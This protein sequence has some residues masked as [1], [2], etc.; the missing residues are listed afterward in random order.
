MDSLTTSLAGTPYFLC[1]NDRIVFVNEAF[2]KWTGFLKEELVGLSLFEASN[3]LNLHPELPFSDM[4]Q[5]CLAI[6]FM[7]DKWPKQAN[8]STKVDPNRQRCVYCFTEAPNSDLNEFLSY[9]VTLFRLNR[10]GVAVYHANGICLLA[11]STY[12]SYLTQGESCQGMNAEEILTGS[13]YLEL[14]RQ[15]FS[16]HQAIY[17]EDYELNTG[18]GKATYW[19][20]SM[21]PIFN[22]GSLNYVIHQLWDET[23]SILRNKEIERQKDLYDALFHSI[24]DGMILADCNLRIL[25]MNQAAK[26]ILPG[27][28]SKS[29]I[30]E[31][32]EL[33]KFSLL[34][35]EP[36]AQDTLLTP[37]CIL[38][39]TNNNLKVQAMV[40]NRR[41]I[42]QISMIPIMST[43]DEVSI[44]Y[45]QIIDITAAEKNYATQ[46]TKGQRDALNKIILKHNLGFVRFSWPDL[47]I[48]GYNLEM[49]ELYS[50]WQGK[51]S[52]NAFKKGTPLSELDSHNEIVNC[53]TDNKN[54]KKPWI[55]VVRNKRTRD[56][57]TIEFNTILIHDSIHTLKEI[58]ITSRN[59]TKE[60]DERE[61]MNHAIQ[62]QM[63]LF[64]NISH[65]LKT[66]LNLIHST[67]QLM[68]I[69]I[70]KTTLDKER[71]RK[72][73]RVIQ[74]NSMRMTRL[75]NNILDISKLESGFFT[76]NPVNIDIVSTTRSIV[77]SVRE[78]TSVHSIRIHFSTS[79]MQRV[80]ACDPI[81]IERVLLNLISNAIKFSG[82]QGDIY[83]RIKELNNEIVIY[84]RDTGRGI[85]HEHLAFL[86]DRFYRAQDILSRDT[87]GTGIGLSLV[88]SLIE[89]LHG[90][91]TMKSNP[92]KGTTVRVSLPTATLP[93]RTNAVSSIEDSERVDRIKVEFS[94]IYN[95]H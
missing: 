63:N 36:L 26:R 25:S 27:V 10:Y 43:L 14:I 94:D 76:I 4:G 34:N 75:I 66:P 1:K 12:T 54:N 41:R 29:S 18:N 67:N 64:T 33:A 83:V 58:L 7:K 93:N 81:I 20:I 80:I 38:N 88:K 30:L 59:V 40:Q 91:I 77:D 37:E 2:L 9:A 19:D 70:S 28:Q 16:E 17:L 56:K 51:N 86:F 46:Y 15:V 44:F 89:L 48:L 6:L 49:R 79:I 53:I 68:Q 8:L 11:N 42:L 90:K 13:F 74:Q 85:E 5:D 39:R 61:L 55:L 72:G 31:L 82:N 62:S 69:A 23:A 92:G 45:I 57:K 78:Y 47:T 95:L 84:V 52:T 87:E 32:F 22:E 3:L 35:G 73:L 21:V 50:F 60:M 24:S 65:E 71:F